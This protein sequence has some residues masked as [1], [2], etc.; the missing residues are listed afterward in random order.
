MSHVVLWHKLYSVVCECG[1]SVF[2]L[3]CLLYSECQEKL[4][5]LAGVKEQL[6]QVSQQRDTLDSKLKA[7][8]TLNANLNS[9]LL[10]VQV[11]HKKDV[12]ICVKLPLSSYAPWGFKTYYS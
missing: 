10:T 9:E 12:M 4:D 5:V 8:E 2:F 3:A 6:E 7:V 1:V 11:P